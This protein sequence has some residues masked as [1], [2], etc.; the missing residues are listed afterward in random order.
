VLGQ[1]FSAFFFNAIAFLLLAYACS[2][3]ASVATHK[4]LFFFLFVL[5]VFFFPFA[6]FFSSFFPYCPYGPPIPSLAGIGNFSPQ[7]PAPDPLV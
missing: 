7:A 2:F 6:P 3:P 5:F 1:I 4:V